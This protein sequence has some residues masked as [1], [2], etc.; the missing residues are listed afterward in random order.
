MLGKKPILQS[1]PHAKPRILREI[2]AAALKSLPPRRRESGRMLCDLL[3]QRDSQAVATLVGSGR[4]TG[5]LAF[6]P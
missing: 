5:S 6:A 4:V 1:L 3:E 2:G